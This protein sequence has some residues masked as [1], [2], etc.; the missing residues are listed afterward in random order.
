MVRADQPLKVAALRRFDEAGAPVAAH[1]VERAQCSAVVPDHE[2]PRAAD[3]DGAERP[4]PGDLVLP[5]DALPTSAEQALDLE[6]VDGGV[7]EER[8]RKGARSVERATHA[9]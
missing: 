2:Y 4:R 5:S 8:A 7:A 6:V 9:S 1:V 3:L